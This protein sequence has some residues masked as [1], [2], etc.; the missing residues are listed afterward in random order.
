MTINEQ[1]FDLI[2]VALGRKVCLSHSPSACEWGELYAMAKKQSLVGVCFAGVQKLYN[3]NANDDD[4][5]FPE[6]KNTLSQ[7]PLASLA[8]K[9]EKQFLEEEDKKAHDD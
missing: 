9:Q 6:D 5:F 4:D 2:R 1:F 3:D 7:K 8:K